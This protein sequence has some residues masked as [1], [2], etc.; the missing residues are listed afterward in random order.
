M[1]LKKDNRFKGGNRKKRV[2]GIAAL[3]GNEIKL[4][5][6]ITLVIILLLKQVILKPIIIESKYK[7]RAIF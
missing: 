4:L 7:L 1:K 2:N 5:L 3:P 6:L